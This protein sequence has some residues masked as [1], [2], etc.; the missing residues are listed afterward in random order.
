MDRGIQSRTSKKW[1]RSFYVEYGGNGLSVEM[2]AAGLVL[3]RH[4]DCELPTCSKTYFRK[5]WQFRADTKQ[6]C[7]LGHGAGRSEAPYLGSIGHVNRS[8]G[9][10][11]TAPDDQF[12]CLYMMDFGIARF[13]LAKPGLRQSP[14]HTGRHYQ[15]PWNW[16]EV[17]RNGL[18]HG[19]SPPNMCDKPRPS[20]LSCGKEEFQTCSIFGTGS[21]GGIARRH[22]AGTVSL[23]KSLADR[24]TRLRRGR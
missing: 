14:L 21:T 17:G 15:M 19:C 6:K 12:H 1:G 13:A 11:P 4:P 22:G 18:E 16:A 9:S 24:T 3:D 20:Q 5:Q 7:R 8:H 23:V 2:Q 10:Q